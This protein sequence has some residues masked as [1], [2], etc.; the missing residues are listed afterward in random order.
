MKALVGTFNQEG[1]SPWLW[2]PMERLQLK[3]CASLLHA[4]SFC[5]VFRWD[6]VHKPS[7][8]GNEL[9]YFHLIF[10]FIYLSSSV[11]LLILEILHK[12]KITEQDT[13]VHMIFVTSFK[14][15]LK[16]GNSHKIEYFESWNELENL[17]QG[18][19]YTIKSEWMLHNSLNFANFYIIKIYKNV[20][21]RPFYLHHCVFYHRRF[22]RIQQ[23]LNV[24]KWSIICI[25]IS[26]HKNWKTHFNLIFF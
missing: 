12:F 20:D 9:Q 15:S 6:T 14:L 25:E 11:N 16:H 24:F 23:Y 19:I 8:L 2:K 13:T 4:N 5:F 26:V 3:L 7:I 1:P 18:K 10:T 21:F 17:S 22:K